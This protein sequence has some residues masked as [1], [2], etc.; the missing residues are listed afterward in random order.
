MPTQPIT[1]KPHAHTANTGTRDSRLYDLQRWRDMRA[2]HV[3]R[4][5][6]CV[7]CSRKG[8][9]VKGEEVDHI[10]PHCGDERLF[11]DEANLQTLCNPCHSEKTAQEDGLGPAQ[12]SILPKWIRVSMKPL[13]VVCGPPHAGKTTLVRNEASADDLV[14]DMDAMSQELYGKPLHEIPESSRNSILRERNRRLSKFTDNSTDHPRCWLIVTAGTFKQRKFWEDKGAEVR[15]VHPGAALCVQR[16]NQN[17]NIPE[18]FKSIL[19][20]S[21]RMWA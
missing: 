13:I 10:I 9:V 16:I 7:K 21:A 3:H 15:I 6:L 12:A 14:L 2:R 5:P 19:A 8:L 1:H 20:Q 4:S 18:G 11:W 17:P